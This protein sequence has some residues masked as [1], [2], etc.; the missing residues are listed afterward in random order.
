MAVKLF[1]WT[2]VNTVKYIHSF[3]FLYLKVWG[4]GSVGKST[5]C[6]SM[7]IWVQILSICV[8]CHTWPQ[9]LVGR[10]RRVEGASPPVFISIERPCLQGVRWGVTEQDICHSCLTSAFGYT[11]LCYITQHYYFK[12]HFIDLFCVLVCVCVCSCAM[13]CVRRPED[14]FRQA[15]LFLPWGSQGSNSDHQ[16]GSRQ[17]YPL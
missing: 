12:L 2:M 7:R 17:L 14:S 10:D 8:K 16:A 13:A 1:V 5:S 11:H 9:C 3:F 4:A 15:A 6:A